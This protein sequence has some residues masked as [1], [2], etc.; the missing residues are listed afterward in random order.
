MVKPCKHNIQGIG[1]HNIKVL[2]EHSGYSKYTKS[3]DLTGIS[4]GVFTVCKSTH[5]GVSSIKMAKAPPT[6]VVCFVVC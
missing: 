5:L 1:L 4:S 2:Y 3:N 6:N